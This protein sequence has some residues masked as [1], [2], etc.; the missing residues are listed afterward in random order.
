[1]NKIILNLSALLLTLLPVCSCSGRVDP[2]TFTPGP[3][4]TETPTPE[5]KIPYE[6]STTI[7]KTINQGLST[8]W[9]ANDAINV[10]HA[11]SGTTS[12]VDD[13]EFTVDAA[14]TGRFSGELANTLPEDGTQDWY[15]FYPY[16]SYI[17]T[18]A[19]KSR[20]W[21]T[22]GGTTQIQT[23]NDSK[24][25]LAG[26]S[27][28]LYGI[29]RNVPSSDCPSL[30]MKQLASV[31]EVNVTN[32]SGGD[33]TVNMVKFISTEAI[34]GT[35]YIDFSSD[36][37]SFKASGTSYVS[38]TATLSVS[39]G[40]AI[41]D[42][43]SAK[44]YLAV[45][46]HTVSSGS[47]LTLIVNG[48]K[49]T[50]KLSKNVQFNAGSIKTI[51]FNYDEDYW[52]ELPAA[53][54]DLAVYTYYGD[55]D[56][57]RNYTHIYDP[58]SMTSLWTAY[59]LSNSYM[60]TLDRPGSWYYSPYITT[61]CQVNVRSHSY[62]DGTYSRGHM[63]PNASRNG[64]ATMQK[65][66][67]YVTNQVPQIQNNFNSGIWQTLEEAVQG[68]VKTNVNEEIYV[69]TG[70]AFQKVGET[71]TINYVSPTDDLSQQVPIPNYFYKLVLRVKKNTAG[72][73]TSACT[74]GFW[75][76]HKAYKNDSY[77]NYNVSVRQ[78]EEWT[79]FDFFVNLPDDI[80]RSAESQNT[81]WSNFVAF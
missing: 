63:C 65:Q 6:I 79:G 34:V 47:S 23:G 3:G 41:A 68:V 71:K 78:V 66:T 62:S 12:Y 38:S 69:V 48:C 50:L 26:P 11:T 49:K 27:C 4:T 37:P 5:L 1:M 15:V 51:S 80:E 31:V 67:F 22:I 16:N 36:T 46:P 42:G 7:T 73:V 13:G 70:V 25:H 28:P 19:N 56:A 40:A 55:D 33:L 76:E 2:E 52:L 24:S 53:N 59:P 10:F 54:S 81:T 21:T 60:G 8:T 32:S 75:F 64:N 61:D 74:V 45:K 30:E 57:T 39:G 9:A 29:A 17:S 77:V 18:P 20:G 35:Y 44:F 72:V 58:S 14:L 43:S